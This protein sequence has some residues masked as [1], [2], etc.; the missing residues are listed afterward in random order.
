MPQKSD[1]TH[2][3][4]GNM[5]V[6]YRRERSNIWQCRYKVGGDWQR[7]STRERELKDAIAAAKD[8]L[9]AAIARKRDNVAVVTQR[10]KSIAR[11]ALQRLEEETGDDKGLRKHRDYLV[12]IEKYLI[13]FFGKYNVSNINTELLDDFDSWRV[14]KMGKKPSRSTLQA[15]NAALSYVFDEAEIC[16]YLN[17]S[18]RPK[19]TSTQDKACNRRSD[20]DEKEL[21]ALTESFDEWIKRNNLTLNKGIALLLGDYAGILLETGAIPGSQLVDLHWDAS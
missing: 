14:V 3:L 20:F 6:V 17:P 21:Q 1:T 12:V 13:P 19:L 11:R 10:F 16:E 8:L 5:L 4:M 2:T 15:H 9:Y 18:T 7:A